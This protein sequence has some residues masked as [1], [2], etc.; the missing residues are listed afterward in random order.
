[1]YQV[2]LT[3]WEEVPR[4]CWCGEAGKNII[5]AA[6]MGE[7]GTGHSLTST[8]TPHENLAALGLGGRCVAGVTCSH[9]HYPVMKAES[10]PQPTTNA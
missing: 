7:V 3:Y 1:M 4:D 2:S 5:R 6:E 9:L 10:R 8:L